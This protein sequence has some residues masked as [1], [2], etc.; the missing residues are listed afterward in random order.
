MPTADP[1]APR[2]ML[3]PPTR[4]ATSVPRSWRTSAISLAM[5]STTEPSIVSSTAALANASPESLRTTRRQGGEAGLGTGL[6]PD[7]NLREADDRGRSEHLADCLLV[8]FGVGL[9]E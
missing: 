1:V 4:T 7:Q 9:F 8:V 2:Q 6:A 3:P 5:R